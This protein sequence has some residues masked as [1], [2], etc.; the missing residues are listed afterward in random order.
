MHWLE[1]QG[2]RGS[3]WKQIGPAIGRLFF[4]GEA[5]TREDLFLAAQRLAEAGLVK[6]ANIGAGIPGFGQ[7]EMRSLG[8]ECVESGLTIDEFLQSRQKPE[9]KVHY[10]LSGQFPGANISAGGTNFSQHLSTTGPAADNLK[11]VLDAVLE[12]L[13]V[14]GLPAGR[15]VEV[16]QGADAARGEIEKAERDDVALRSAGSRLVE[17]L[18]DGVKSAT[19]SS[20]LLLFK[21]E[22]ARLGVPIEG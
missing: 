6:G 4:F 14:M 17:A 20:L 21:V 1:E 2:Q 7:A 18:T 8:Y 16:Q 19:A 11:I 9:S 22:M 3:S 15:A 12:S 5:F 13:S 10:E